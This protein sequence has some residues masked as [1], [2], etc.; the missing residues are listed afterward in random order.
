MPEPKLPAQASEFLH[1][2]APNGQIKVAVLLGNETIW[3]A[4]EHMADCLP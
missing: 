4:R 3:L 2:T 1:H